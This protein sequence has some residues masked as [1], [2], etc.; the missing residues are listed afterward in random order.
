[1]SISPIAAYK[2][3]VP[4]VTDTVLSLST[5]QPVGKTFGDYVKN[6][7]Q[8]TLSSVHNFEKMGS[9]SMT[10]KVSDLDLITAVNETELNL[11]AFKVVWEKFL[12]EF[13]GIVEKTAL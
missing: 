2:A 1:M 4:N 3:A 7:V 10:G 6:T 5:E 12:Q 13:K 11:Q 8:D 9:A